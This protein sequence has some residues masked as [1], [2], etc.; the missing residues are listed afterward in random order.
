MAL[1]L[2]SI[3]WNW[4]FVGVTD[5]TSPFFFFV[6]SYG[7]LILFCPVISVCRIVGVQQVFVQ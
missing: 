1:I 5:T 3:V 6:H 7:I 4:R 2:F